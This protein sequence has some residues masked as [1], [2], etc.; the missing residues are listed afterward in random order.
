MRRI[1]DKKDD[2]PVFKIKG[3]KIASRDTQQHWNKILSKIEAG[4]NHNKKR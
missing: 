3:R 2:L 4:G 1:S